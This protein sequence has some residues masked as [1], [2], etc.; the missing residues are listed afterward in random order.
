MKLIFWSTLFFVE[1]FFMLPGNMNM[2]MEVTA[3][4][5]PIIRK[6]SHQ[7]PMNLGSFLGML[8]FTE[9]KKVEF[10]SCE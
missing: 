2:G 5:M 9:S 4:P 1:P 6:P 7:A 8:T 3:R 10:V